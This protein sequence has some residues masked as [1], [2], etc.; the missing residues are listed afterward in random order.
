MNRPAIPGVSNCFSV[1]VEGFIESNLQSFHIPEKYINKVRENYEIESNMEC[2]LSLLEESDTRA[3]CFFLGRL[4]VE[5]PALVRKV[6]QLG[7]EIACHSYMHHRVFGV[8]KDEF[9]QKL[10]GAKKCLEDVSGKRVYGFRAPDFSI[11]QASLWAL[12]ILNELGFTYDSSIYPVGL[13]DVYGIKGAEPFVHKLPNGLIEFP[14]STVSVFG[15]RIPFGG[16][17][18]FR[19]YPLFL[20]QRCMVEVNRL[21]QPCMFYIHPYEVGP[22]MP[23]ISSLSFYRKFRH[24][25]NCRQGARRVK[26]LLR[27]FKFVSACEI[28]EERGI[29][30]DVRST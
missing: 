1:D 16:G 7:H 26:E 30:G 29:L 3:T 20:T 2:V 23:R 6:A 24:Y 22:C 17:G 15:R 27:T 12:D 13:H 28:M 25:Y 19:L 9:K 14:L 5:L 11:T 18:Y 21:G 10:D 4:A 8:G